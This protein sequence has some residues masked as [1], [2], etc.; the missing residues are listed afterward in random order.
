MMNAAD[1]IVDIG[2]GAGI[3]G[4]NIVAEG[5]LSEIKQN[6]KS[7]TGRFLIGEN[8]IKYS[9]IKHKFKD[10]RLILKNASGNNL[11]NITLSIP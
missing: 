3:H 9:K 8:K 7:I 10:K 6:K 5:I 2:P 1:W 4:G 11:K